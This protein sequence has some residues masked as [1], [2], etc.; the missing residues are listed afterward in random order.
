MATRR[1]WR[2]PAPLASALLLGGALPCAAHAAAS[3]A[4][5]ANVAS[6]DNAAPIVDASGDLVRLG[7][8]DLYLEVTLNGT[9]RGLMQFVYRDDH[10][11]ASAANLRTL[12]FVLPAGAPDPVR[13]DRLSGLKVDYNASRQTLT[14]TAPLALL[15]L[16]T[17]ILDTARQSSPPATTSPGA[18]VNYS[19]YG[20]YGTRGNRALNAFT[21]LRAFNRW[22]VFSSTQ[23]AQMSQNTNGGWQDHMVRLDTSWTTSL[24]DRLL[25]IRVGDTLTD[26]LSWSRSSRIAGVQIGTDFALQPYFVTTPIPAFFGSTTLPSQIQLY[27]NGMRRYSGEIP[28]GPFQ[29]N[30]LPGISGAGNAQIV[31]TDALGQT[32]TMNFPLY[33]ENQL[34]RHGLTQWSAELGAVRLNYGLSS[35]DYGDRPV[36]SATW[37][38]GLSDHL[39]VESHAEGTNGLADGGIGGVWLLGKDGGVL[40]AAIAGSTYD[41][42]QGSQYSLG[43]SWSSER[44]A[45]SMNALGTQGQYHDVPSLY[46]APVPRLSDQASAS[47]NFKGIGSLGLSYVQLAYSGQP[48]SRYAS[49]YWYRNV[50][51]S[52]SLNLSVS[53]DLQNSANRSVFLLAT[54]ALGHQVTA[55]ANLF[56]NGSQTGLQLSAT[57]AVPSEG[58]LGWRAALS[59]GGGQNGGQGELDYLGTYGQA[60]AGVYDLAGARYGYGSAIGSLV[61]MD[62][63]VFAARQINNGFAVVSTDGIPDVPVSLENNPIGHTGSDGLLLVTP[64][65]AYQ[66]NSISIN[67]LDLPADLQ[68]ARVRANATPADRSGTLVTFPITRIRA[69]TLLLVDA[70]GKPVPLG[71]TVRIRGSKGPPAY[72]GYG[73]ETYLDS[74]QAHNVLEVRTPEGT[75]RVQFDFPHAGNSIPQIGPLTCKKASP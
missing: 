22:G 48:A 36:A 56:R 11:W 9:A 26:A 47:Y 51:R 53:Q 64:V 43:Y 37:R 60:S 45:L 10:L 16:H 58:G 46:G 13:L 8:Y 49:A 57:Q 42:A 32:T 19:L 17:T 21:E 72:V 23:L 4:T 40:S 29:L 55:S 44:L 50:G 5:L 70:Q 62:G 28:A 27:V 31:L 18:L 1:A 59:Q 12:G 2:W 74:L 68:I 71:S 54:L 14:L 66:R 75:C 6:P 25:S 15:R 34:L 52:L 61:L 67:T 41:G 39:T 7:G 69:A 38:Y 33:G 30:T 73:G 3:A 63:H 65:N 20:I 35:F 24:P